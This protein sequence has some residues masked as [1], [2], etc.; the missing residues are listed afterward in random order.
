MKDNYFGKTLKQLRLERKLSQ[1]KFG[2]A[3]GVVNQAVSS[4]ETGTNEPDFD[5]LLKIAKFFNVTA[6]FLLGDEII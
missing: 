3:M 6:S 2:E 1:R 4:W 5:T